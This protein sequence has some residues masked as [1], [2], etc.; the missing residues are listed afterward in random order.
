MLTGLLRAMISGFLGA[1]GFGAL[2]HAPRKGILCGSAIG[3]LGYTAY[4]LIFQL[5]GSELP[6]MF[7]GALLAAVLGQL[8]ARKL[9][10]ISTVFVTIA[11]LPLV[12]GIGLFRS[13]SAL[14]QGNMM[15]GANL[16]AHAMSLILMIV[17]G[18]GLGSAL[19]SIRRAPAAK[20]ET[21]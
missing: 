2:L 18:T 7:V 3:A 17:M 12:P 11:I 4:W 10:M 13:M 15:Q 14:G 16:A 5:T 20:E 21:P 8:A 19:F 6:A 9:H 1:A